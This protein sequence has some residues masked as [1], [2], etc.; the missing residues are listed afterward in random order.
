MPPLRGLAMTRSEG[1]QVQASVHLAAV[2]DR[3]DRDL[4]GLVV[5]G[6]DHPLVA[7]AHPQ[8]GP[9]VSQRQEAGWPRIGD[10]AVDDLGDG[11]AH[12]RSSCCSERRKR[13]RT[14]MM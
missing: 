3:R 11:L 6:V 14:S 12:G 1:L 13:G 7:G 8:E 4:A 5:H 2:P 9:M 10:Q